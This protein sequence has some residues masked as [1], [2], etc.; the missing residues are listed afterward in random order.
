M[1]LSPIA[2]AKNSTQNIGQNFC[3]KLALLTGFAI[4]LVAFGTSSYAANPAC[5]SV[6]TGSVSLSGD[7]DCT[8]SGGPALIFSGASASL[9]GRGF[10]IRSSDASYLI[11]AQSAKFSMR[12]T[13]LQ[14]SSSAIGVLVLNSA[15]VEIEENLIDGLGTGVQIYSGSVKTSVEVEGNR[16]RNSTQFAVRMLSEG[17]GSI[18]CPEIEDNDFSGSGSYALH[19]TI[20]AADLDLGS[21]R[22]RDSQGAV[23]LSKGEFLIYKLDLSD[24][25]IVRTAITVSDAKA[26][27]FDRVNVSSS[28]GAS[29]DQTRGGI[30]LY[31]V[32]AIQ[33]DKVFA[34]GMDFGVKV[35]TDSGVQSSM[36]ITRSE[37]R[38][39]AFAGLILQSYDSTSFGKVYV[40]DNDFRGDLDGFGVYVAPGTVLGSGSSIKINRF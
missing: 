20:D 2:F 27:A 15:K 6:I 10:Q 8:G 33:M 25:R 32:K 39:E 21:N 34:S 9:D 18:R 22:F 36:L 19:L 28:L 31:R 5:G 35:A 26:I 3:Q 7:L 1:K 23:Y 16:I 30:S 12:K 11:L 17:T 29:V 13:V 40:V 38:K 14:G 37:M 4:G 24:E